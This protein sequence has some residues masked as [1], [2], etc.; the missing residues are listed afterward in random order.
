V[1]EH[2]FEA[3]IEQDTHIFF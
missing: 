3:H 1:L 2:D